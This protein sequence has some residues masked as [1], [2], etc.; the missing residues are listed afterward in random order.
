MKAE[1]LARIR[2]DNAEKAE[3]IENDLGYFYENGMYWNHLDEI[4]EG[5][6]A[7]VDRLWISAFAQN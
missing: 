4:N 2:F 3:R 7:E 1:I 5:F 6:L